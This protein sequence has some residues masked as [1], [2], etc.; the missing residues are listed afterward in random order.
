ML[1]TSGI[2]GSVARVCFCSLERTVLD[3]RSETCLNSAFWRSVSSEPRFPFCWLCLGWSILWE[4]WCILKDQTGQT[5]TGQRSFPPCLH[6]RLLLPTTPSAAGR[7]DLLHCHR[8]R[9]FNCTRRNNR[10]VYV[11]DLLKPAV[12]L[13]PPLHYC[14]SDMKNINNG[15]SFYKSY[16]MSTLPTH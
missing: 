15:W 12:E 5:T 7:G 9:V 4:V 13:F 3:I 8:W 10:C 16:E 14:E 2:D 1:L 6:H 11:T